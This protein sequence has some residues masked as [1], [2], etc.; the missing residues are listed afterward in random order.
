MY[1]ANTVRICLIVFDHQTL[2]EI[3]N[4]QNPPNSGMT[5]H[6]IRCFQIAMY[7]LF[8]MHML[9]CRQDIGYNAYR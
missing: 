7:N 4:L 6:D 8:R 2:S 3:D 5:K 9:N 1:G